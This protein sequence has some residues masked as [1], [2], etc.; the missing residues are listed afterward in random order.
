M[1][2]CKLYHSSSV[3]NKKLI[4]PLDD[5]IDNERQLITLVNNIYFFIFSLEMS[6]T[7]TLKHK[8]TKCME[9]FSFYNPTA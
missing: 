5:T 2:L 1:Q 6:N 3:V 8:W 7:Q 9:C 4:I